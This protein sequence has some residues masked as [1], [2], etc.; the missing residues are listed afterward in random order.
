MIPAQAP[1]AGGNNN[2]YKKKELKIRAA[3]DDNDHR[4]NLFIKNLLGALSFTHIILNIPSDP[5][6]IIS[7]VFQTQKL[8][9]REVK[10]SVQVHKPSEHQ[11]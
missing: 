2:D 1:T 8:R 3:N 4:T 10:E 5:K 7:V 9:F 11:T 6:S